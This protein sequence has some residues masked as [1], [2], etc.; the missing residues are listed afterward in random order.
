MSN[1][2]FLHKEWPDIFAIAKEAEEL[3]NEKARSS[4]VNSRAALEKGVRWM[5]ENDQRLFE[6]YDKRKTV[7]SLLL[8][9]SLKKVTEKPLR[10][11][12]HLLQKLGNEAAHGEI[13]DSEKANT[14]IKILFQ[15]FSHLA[16]SYSSDDID[17]P[18]FD[19]SL[20]P[21]GVKVNETQ[22]ELELQV[23]KLEALFKKDK[24]QREILLEQQESLESLRKELEEKGKLLAKRA[25]KRSKKVKLIPSLIP[26]S[27]TRKLF[28]DVLL[29]K[30]FFI[31]L[32]N[33]Q[34]LG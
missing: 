12:L 32:N 4:L 13:T 31:I 18:V 11:Q 6:D 19:E 22:R 28:I 20:I 3:S 26:E 9:P 30:I 15:F 24:T 16:V 8:A 25:E 10:R 27:V 2:Q 33:I 5:Y 23:K 29:N 34:L 17:T 14:C 1:F 21:T 7:G